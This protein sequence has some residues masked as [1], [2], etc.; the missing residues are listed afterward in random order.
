MRLLDPELVEDREDVGHRYPLRIGL[1]VLRHVGR[2]IAAGGEG[3]AA[4]APREEIHLRL[5]RQ[6]VAAEFVDEHDRRPFAILLEIEADT[7]ARGG[8][9]HLL[10]PRAQKSGGTSLRRRALSTTDGSRSR[11]ATIHSRGTVVLTLMK[12]SP[13]RGV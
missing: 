12:R 8:V 7:V 10:P 13:N 3:D 6:M 9:G 5:P 11:N 2:R 1:D 4:V